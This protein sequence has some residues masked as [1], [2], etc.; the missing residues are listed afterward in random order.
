MVCTLGS[1]NSR[2]RG[3]N[4]VFGLITVVEVVVVVVTGG[5][6]GGGEGGAVDIAVLVVLRNGS[7]NRG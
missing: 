6:W 7:Y 4:L 5:G 3:G 2:K 1:F